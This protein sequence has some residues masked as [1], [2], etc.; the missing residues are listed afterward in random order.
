MIEVDTCWRAPDSGQ[1]EFSTISPLV[2]LLVLRGIS[3]IFLPR[4]TKSC[5]SEASFF[6]LLC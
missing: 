4:V 3:Q 1:L 2:F 5:E 6:F